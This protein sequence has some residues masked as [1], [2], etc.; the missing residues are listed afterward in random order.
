MLPA[1]D[2]FMDELRAL[3]EQPWV[4]ESPEGVVVAFNPLGGMGPCSDSPF[5]IGIGLKGVDFPECAPHWVHTSP[6]T[7]DG[8]HGTADKEYEI[9]GQR[10]LAMSRPMHDELWGKLPSK[11]VGVYVNRHLKPLLREIC[12][13]KSP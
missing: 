10:W 11:T 3:G 2:I 8:R 6:P 12:G 4:F 13:T 5:A 9:D 1:V 7:S